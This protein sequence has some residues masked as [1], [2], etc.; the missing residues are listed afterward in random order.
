MKIRG[1]SNFCLKYLEYVE[2]FHAFFTCL[3][4]KGNP[5]PPGRLDNKAALIQLSELGIGG[6][7]ISQNH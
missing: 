4:E 6:E 1:K 7:T 5:Y 2:M 3:I